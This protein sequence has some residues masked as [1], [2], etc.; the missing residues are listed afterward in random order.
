[1]TYKQFLDIIIDDAIT[2]AKE[3]YKHDANKRDGAISGL[4][5]CRDRDPLELREV[6]QETKEYVDKFMFGHKEP[7]TYWWY[8]CYQSEVEWVCNVASAALKEF[9]NLEPILPNMPT[10][11]G[12]LKAADIY[13]NHKN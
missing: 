1:M 6:Y 8:R 2:A 12:Y 9:M 11:R 3:T 7:K 10:I 5:A 13:K 4:T